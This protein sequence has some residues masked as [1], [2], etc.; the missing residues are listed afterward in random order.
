MRT[1]PVPLWSRNGGRSQLSASTLPTCVMSPIVA[2]VVGTIL[3]VINQ[4]DVLRRGQATTL[5]WVKIAPTFLVP[6]CVSNYG[7]LVAS[8]RKMSN[9]PTR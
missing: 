9:E 3:L 5:V 8:H 6:F 2:A 7:V 1:E 4:L